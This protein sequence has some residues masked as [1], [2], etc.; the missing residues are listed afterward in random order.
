MRTHRQSYVWMDEWVDLSDEDLTKL[1]DE[2]HS[3]LNKTL[4]RGDQQKKAEV[5]PMP[6]APPSIEKPAPAPASPEPP[7]QTAE[8]LAAAEEKRELERRENPQPPPRR[9]RSR[10][11]EVG[12]KLKAKL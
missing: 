2:I 1:E 7:K 5:P 12:N 4:N 9:F 11:R 6:G 10:L 8:E 3:T